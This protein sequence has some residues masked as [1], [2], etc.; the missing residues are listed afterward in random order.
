VQLSAQPWRQNVRGLWN[1]SHIYSFMQTDR[2]G[3]SLLLTLV[4][5]LTSSSSLRIAMM[6]PLFLIVEFLESIVGKVSFCMALLRLL[7]Q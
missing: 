5:G 7:L 3:L 2:Q 6:E 1:E 4:H